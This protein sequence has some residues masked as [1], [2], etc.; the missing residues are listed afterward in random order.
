VSDFEIPDIPL[1]AEAVSEQEELKDESGGCRTYAFIGS[2][3]GGGRLAESFYKLGYKKVIACNTAPQDLKGL[4]LIPEDQKLLLDAGV[5][6]AGKDMRIGEDAM[7]KGQ[8]RLYELMMRKFGKVDHI[9]ICVGAGGGSGGG[10]SLVLLATVK[11]Y[12][13]YMGYDDADKRVG[14]IVSLPTNGEC[15]SP[16]VGANAKF[17]MEKLAEYADGRQLSPLIVVD[18]DKIQRLFPDATVKSFWNKVNDTVAG[19]FHIFNVLPTK[20][21]NYTTFDAADYS[22]IM[23]AG[24][25]MIMGSTLVKECKPADSIANALRI[26]LERTLLASGFDLRTATHAAAVVVGGSSIFDSVPGLMNSIEGGFDALAVLTGDALVHRGVYE[27]NKDRLT[28]YTL[29]G[30]LHAP[31]KRIAQLTRFQGVVGDD[32]LVSSMPPPKFGSRLYDE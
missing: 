25:F 28:V 24:G 5:S 32:R 1:M 9:L 8:H 3:Q 4:E 15:A 19:L 18:N 7:L 13:A 16:G 12:M 23:Q 17:L 27:D 31:S 21:T 2:G 22:S 26:N 30:G 29:V 14:F 6:G 20:E 10:S 11:K